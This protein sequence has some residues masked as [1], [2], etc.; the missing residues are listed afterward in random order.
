MAKLRPGEELDKNFKAAEWNRHVEVSNWAHRNKM[1]GEGGGGQPL[2]VD[3]SRVLIKND[4]GGNLRLGEVV[5]LQDN[6]LG[7]VAEPNAV[8]D[9]DTPDETKPFAICLEPIPDG[10][11]GPAQIA[12]R[13]PA[14]VNVQATTDRWAQ[15]ISGQDTLSGHRFC[16][17]VRLLHTAG[18]TG[19]QLMWVMFQNCP[20]RW[21]GKA[22]GAIN[23]GGNSGTVSVWEGPLGSE[24]DTTFN[25][26]V[27]NRTDGDIGSGDWCEVVLAHR[28]LYVVP[29]QC[30]APE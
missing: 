13:C 11:I 4:T 18:S 21:I 23:G 2:I 29:W 1:L 17:S 15:V 7:A 27:Y 30:E 9:A 8:F 26:S 6:S 20:G 12:G 5:E 3:A 16:G 28:Q 25:L 10:K 24:T 22:D 14:L 19:E